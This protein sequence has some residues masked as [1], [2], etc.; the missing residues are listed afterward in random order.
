VQT[1]WRYDDVIGQ[2]NSEQYRSDRLFNGLFVYPHMT[3]Y[4]FANLKAIQKLNAYATAHCGAARKS[5][6]LRLIHLSLRILKVISCKNGDALSRV[7]PTPPGT[8]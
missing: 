5:A 2:C 4:A 8:R 1:Y 6:R 7:H 3:E